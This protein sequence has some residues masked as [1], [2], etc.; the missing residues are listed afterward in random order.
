MQSSLTFKQTGGEEQTEWQ[1]RHR[2]E[3]G[4]GGEELGERHSKQDHNDTVDYN[5]GTLSNA[6]CEVKGELDEGG[7]LVHHTLKQEEKQ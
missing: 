5:K 4:S 7:E 6:N 3:R 1:R 2:E